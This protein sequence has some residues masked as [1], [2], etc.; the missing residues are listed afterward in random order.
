MTKKISFLVIL[1]LFSVNTCFSQEKSK[2]ELKKEAKENER[3][4]KEQQIAKLIDS[5]IFVF[6]ARTAMPSGG[7]SI[8]LTS[9][10]SVKFQPNLIDSHLPFFGR[11]FSAPYGAEYGGLIFKGE[12]LQFI[13][14]KGKKNYI[15]NIEVKD[16]NETYSL[17]LTVGLRGS[18]LLRVNS[19]NRSPMSFN[20][21]IVEL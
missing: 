12:P 21:D 4:V 10:Y 5:K 19:N 20:G 2:R 7:R 1:I 6:N 14:K 11:A 17:T 3:L 15:I 16:K 13:I 18:A 9:S 8:N